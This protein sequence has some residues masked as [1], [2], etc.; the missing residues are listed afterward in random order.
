MSG[1]D[2]PW[3]G[4]LYHMV[5]FLPWGSSAMGFLPGVGLSYGI[6]SGGTFAIWYNFSRSER[7]GGHMAPL[8]RNVGVPRRGMRPAGVSGPAR[9]MA[10]VGVRDVKGRSAVQPLSVEAVE[11][12]STLDPEMNVMS[13]WKTM[14][15][16]ADRVAPAV[17]AD[18]P[19]LTAAGA[20]F[21]AVAE[22]HA[23]ASVIDDDILVVQASEQRTVCSTDPGKVPETLSI[24]VGTHSSPSR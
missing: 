15:S 18:V 19:V 1:G 13:G 10:P 22:V 7:D 12:S 4:K 16:G 11:F 2:L 14:S 8:G 21:S 23:S 5:L 17:V 9:R 20:T 3:M 6:P 24:P